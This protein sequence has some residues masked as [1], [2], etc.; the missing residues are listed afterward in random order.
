MK[1]GSYRLRAVSIRRRR[2]A[3]GTYQGATKG[4]G[5]MKAGKGLKLPAAILLISVISACGGS[6]G[7]TDSG[8]AGR[9]A[10]GA[11]AAKDEAAELV[12]YSNNGN[13]VESFDDN[14]GNALR[15]KFPN[16]TI[17]YIQS[18]TGTT[19]P[20]ML[21]S[22]TKFDIFF[23]TI[24]NFE[25]YGI[26]AGMEYDMR[27]LIKTHKVDLGRL[28][29]VYV[30]Y[31]NGVAN[32]SIYGFPIQNNVMVLYYN[33][34][35]FEKFGVP[36]P[37]DGMSW[38]EA[39][40]LGKRVTRHE[41]GKQY[42]GLSVNP[43]NTVNQNQFSLSSVDPASL[44]PTLSSNARWR[45]IYETLFMRPTEDA[46]VR[47][48]IVRIKKIPDHYTF[49]RDQNV[50]MYGYSSGLMSALAAELRNV[51]WDIA[52]LPTF[53]DMPGIGAQPY[54]IE[55]GI[56]SFSSNKDAAMKALSYL[57]SDEYQE[58][59]A[60]KGMMPVLASGEVQKAFGQDSE[61]KDKRLSA[62]F[63]NKM[64]PI[65]L[66]TPPYGA[67]ADKVYTNAALLLAQ[68]QT[69]INSLFRTTEEEAEKVIQDLRQSAK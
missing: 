33:K 39:I 28:D 37:K 64:A 40:E 58:E 15:R 67:A 31:M 5:S 52:S 26:E 27:E 10:G 36:F 68:G 9:E 29:P 65:S 47:S 21:A 50:A 30:D 43:A 1:R 34:T 14:F 12:F 48:E 6:S 60:R 11:A 55:M 17:K 22:G 46:S 61:F 63:Y 44:K 62:V 4:D 32:G 38:D 53:H 49:V 57:I 25:R 8:E 56:T 19:L 42:V 41:G 51:D 23:H 24:G 3:N 16:Y 54:P 66:K 13:S 59:R 35:I 18:T 45:T 7:K 2:Q 20:D 69:D